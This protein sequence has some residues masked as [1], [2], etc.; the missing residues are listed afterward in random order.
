MGTVNATTLG[1]G[2]KSA[3]VGDIV[4]G[5][6]KAWVNFNSVTTTTISKAFNIGSLTD[7]G[8]GDTTLNFTNPMADAL[9]SVVATM[10]TDSA[11]GAARTIGPR[12]SGGSLLLKTTT[13]VR[14]YSYPAT[15]SPDQVIAIFN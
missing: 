8:T 7:N 6:A 2:T 1:N 14:I 12:M 11:W 5:Y 9:Y 10:P 4:D 3:P 13:Q 15:D